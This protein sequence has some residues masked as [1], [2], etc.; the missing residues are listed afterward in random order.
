M[1]S[2][3][4]DVQMDLEF[5]TIESRTYGE[6]LWSS[7][8]QQN[9]HIAGQF[10]NIDLALIL[11]FLDD[12]DGLIALKGGT[13]MSFEVD[14]DANG[15]QHGAFEIDI[16]QTSAS[17]QGDLFEVQAKPAQV[18]WFPQEARYTLAPFA[19]QIGQSSSLVDGEFL[20]GLDENYGPTVGFSFRLRDTYL[21]PNDLGVPSNVLDTITIAGWSAPLY[22]AMGIDKLSFR[23][24][25]MELDGQGRIDVLQTGLGFDLTLFGKG[26]SADDL[27]RIWPYFLATE[28][29]TWFVQNVSGGRIDEAKMRF[30]FPVGTVGKPGEDRRIP[31]GGVSIEGTAQNVEL[32]PLPGFPTIEIVD[33]E[34]TFEPLWNYQMMSEAAKLETGML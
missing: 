10:E 25:Q 15:V 31:E 23:D 14:Y 26:A 12:Q 9:R 34:L 33:V 24:D 6:L 13:N 2:F 18:E 5:N 8:G 1:E 4:A 16:S 32:V 17:I 21:R 29:R 30:N 11:P 28:A 20:M 3:G 19:V 22:G 7:G 27:K